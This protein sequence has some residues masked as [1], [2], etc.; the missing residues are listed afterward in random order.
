MSFETDDD[1]AALL[2]GFRG[3]TLPKEKWTHAAHWA[4]ALGLIAED[5]AAAYRDMPGMIRAYNESVGGRN[6]E[7]EGYHETITVASLKAAE[8]ALGAAPEGTP[9]HAVLSDLLAGPC[10]KPDWILDY[11]RRETLF[12]VKARR[13]WVAPDIRA[14]PF[15][16]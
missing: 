10:G 11:W 15:G 4:A 2:E 6:T 14:L 13:E 9:L 7:T 12:S 16:A 1:I 8:H 3:R 5:A